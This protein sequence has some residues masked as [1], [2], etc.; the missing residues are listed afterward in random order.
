MKRKGVLVKTNKGKGIVSD[1]E[2][3]Y[4]LKVLVHLVDDDNNDLLDEHG[5]AVKH[6][7]LKHT[8]EIAGFVD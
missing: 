1:N 4:E 3:W 6:V 7:M 8:I 2:S 5:K